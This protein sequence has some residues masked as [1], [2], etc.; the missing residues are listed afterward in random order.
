[1]NGMFARLAVTELRARRGICAAECTSASCLVGNTA[2]VPPEG[3]VQ[4]GCPLGTHPANLKSNKDCVLCSACVSSCPHTSVDFR[5]RPP[6]AD[7]LDA[8]AVDATPAEVALMFML[9]GS[10]PVHH[11]GAVAAQLGAGADAAWLSAPPTFLGAHAAASAALLAAPGAI[12][13]A[14]DAGARALG[15]RLDAGYRPPPPFVRSAYAWLP[16][17][18]AAI[19][20]HYEDWGLTEAGQLLRVFAGGGLGLPA[21]VVAAVPGGS[22]DPAVVAFLQGATLLVGLGAGVGLTV[23]YSWRRPAAA[24]AP[25]AALMVAAT[26]ELWSL[27]VR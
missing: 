15:P 19:L 21:R 25:Q 13:W 23:K 9:L 5:L 4:D 3:R 20:A 14:V 2:P 17:T 10:V 8:A 1:M 12:A 26:V 6:A 24:A 16:L 27:I 11:L 18:W 22:V 7:I